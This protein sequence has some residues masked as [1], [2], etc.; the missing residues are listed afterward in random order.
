[1]Q[2]RQLGLVS[3]MNYSQNICGHVWYDQA[4]QQAK[5]VKQLFSLGKLPIIRFNAKFT[6]DVPNAHYTKY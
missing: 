3:V 4:R 5:K 6:I 2:I 1:M